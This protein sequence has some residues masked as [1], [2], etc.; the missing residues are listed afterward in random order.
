MVEGV[1]GGALLQT[2]HPSLTCT[3]SFVMSSRCVA[4][5]G[6]WRAWVKAWRGGGGVPCMSCAQARRD[7]VQRDAVS[8]DGVAGHGLGAKRGG[9][10]E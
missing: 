10:R 9:G 6:G 5:D 2:P 1:K 8:P 4:E 3:V 7:A